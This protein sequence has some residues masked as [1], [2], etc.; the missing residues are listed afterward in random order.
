MK[1]KISFYEEEYCQLIKI[2]N[3]GKPINANEFNHMFDS[4]FRGSN[5]EGKDG[6]GLG[7]YI[8]N[9]IMK[10]MDGDIFAE[11]EDGGMSFTIVL[12]QI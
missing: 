2:Y 8:C 1:I 5:V 6:Q 12:Q 11:F 9:N 3:T 7:L 4:F 10:K